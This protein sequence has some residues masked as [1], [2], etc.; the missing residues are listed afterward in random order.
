MNTNTYRELDTGYIVEFPD[1]WYAE[2][3]PKYHWS[4]TKNMNDAKVYKTLRGAEKL[5][6]R[7][8]HTMEYRDLSASVQTVTV[9][10]T[11]TIMRQS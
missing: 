6:E 2:K 5:V 3:Q 11:K 10:T 1:G 7:A 9:G 4:F 8:S